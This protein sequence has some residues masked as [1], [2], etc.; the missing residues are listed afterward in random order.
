[1]EQLRGVLCVLN[2][3][4]VLYEHV[5]F[6]NIQSRF[7]RAWLGSTNFQTPKRPK[8]LKQNYVFKTQKHV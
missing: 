7:E 5:P 1:M 8:G 4:R 6:C 3:L 2:V